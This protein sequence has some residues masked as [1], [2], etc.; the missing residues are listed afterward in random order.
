MAQAILHEAIHAEIARFVEQFQ[1]GVDVNDRPYLFQL[2]AYYK[3]YTDLVDP[4]FNW[5]NAADHQFMVNS[6]I[7]NIAQALREF[8]N[9]RFPLDNYKDYAWDGL[10]K[11]GYDSGHLTEQEEDYNVNLRVQTNQNIQVCD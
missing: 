4:D 1:T 7:N 10:R 3:D 11:Y 5:S 8:D 6:Y 9:N 2:Y